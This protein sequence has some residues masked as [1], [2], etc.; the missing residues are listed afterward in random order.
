MKMSCISVAIF[1]K[2]IKTAFAHVTA[3]IIFPPDDMTSTYLIEGFADSLD[4]LS[5]LGLTG[6]F[7]PHSH[8]LSDICNLLSTSCLA[9]VRVKSS[10]LTPAVQHMADGDKSRSEHFSL[11][12]HLFF[13]DCCLAKSGQ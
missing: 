2:K 8:L 4:L 7:L 6:C 11:V 13:I 12:I 1:V 5:V 3:A 10:V 9:C